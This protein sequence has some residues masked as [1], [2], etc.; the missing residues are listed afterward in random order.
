MSSRSLCRVGATLST[1]LPTTQQ[2]QY[3]PPWRSQ[4]WLGGGHGAEVHHKI[5]SSSPVKQGLGVC[6]PCTNA[7]CGVGV[8]KQSGR[9][10]PSLVWLFIFLEG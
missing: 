5:S 3:R 7:K 4:V 10:G 1:R 9:K 2:R 8:G 6:L